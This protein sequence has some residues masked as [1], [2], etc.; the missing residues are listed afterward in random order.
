MTNLFI[1]LPTGTASNG[2]RTIIAAGPLTKQPGTIPYRHVIVRY[3]NGSYSVHSEGFDSL[4]GT[5]SHL[6]NGHYFEAGPEGFVKAQEKFAER[7]VNHAKM[8]ATIYRETAA[9]A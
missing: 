2:S 4:D 3:E 6:S 9:V 7:I 8:H 1:G 5:K